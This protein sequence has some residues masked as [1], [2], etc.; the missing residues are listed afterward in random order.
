GL[1]VGRQPLEDLIHHRVSSF[2]S[3][4]AHLDKIQCSP[5]LHNSFSDER[6]YEQSDPATYI[7]APL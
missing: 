4:V 6:S 3:I 2:P 5:N 1:L 7:K